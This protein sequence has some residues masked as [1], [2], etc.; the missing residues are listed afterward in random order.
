MTSIIKKSEGVLPWT[1]DSL[2]IV[3][4]ERGIYVIRNLPTQN[5]IVYI[6]YTENLQEELKQQWEKIDK[7]IDDN[8]TLRFKNITLFKDGHALITAKTQEEAQA[9]YSK[10]IGN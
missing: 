10:F 1:V 5:G 2:D 9:I 6:D 3:P 4:A 7:V 8:I